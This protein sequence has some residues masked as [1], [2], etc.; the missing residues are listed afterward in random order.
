MYLD[1]EELL[2]VYLPYTGIQ[3]SQRDRWRD[4]F[5]QFPV[6]SGY[7]AIWRGMWAGSGWTQDTWNHES[8]HLLQW[9]LS[10]N[11][12]G[13]R[14]AR[15]LEEGHATH[16]QYRVGRQVTTTEQWRS[17]VNAGRLNYRLRDIEGERIF[18]VPNGYLLGALAAEYLRVQYGGDSAMTRFW[19]GLASAQWQTAFQ[20]AF[21]VSADS[22]YDAFE[23]WR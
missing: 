2:N 7:R 10:Q 20:N 5:R 12:R 8:T 15:W 22:F 19:T 9:E 14:A 3:E 23:R 18:D 4:T 21:G 13:G 6:F 11:A 17:L 1:I 16:L